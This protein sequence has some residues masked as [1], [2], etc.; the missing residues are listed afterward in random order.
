MPVITRYG[1]LPVSPSV[2]LIL[3]RLGYKRSGGPP[4]GDVMDSI[5][6]YIDRL[7]VRGAFLRVPILKLRPPEVTLADGARFSSAGL[8]ELLVHSI[9]IAFMASTIPEAP[10]MVAEQFAAGAAD[11]AVILDAVAAQCTDAGLDAILALQGA[12]LRSRGLRF[13][14][15]RYS[16]GYGDVPLSFQKLIFDRLELASIGLSLHPESYMLSPE[17][18]V[19]AV[20]GVIKIG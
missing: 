9:E 16:P 5:R 3:H 11:Q 14:R 18:S 7:N 15:R 8:S 1:A 2:D 10:G 19:L 17:K 13:T 20:A 6:R 12:L 4:P